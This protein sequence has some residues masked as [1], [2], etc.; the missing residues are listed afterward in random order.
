[1]LSNGG[2]RWRRDHERE[3]RELQAKLGELTVARDFV[4]RGSGRRAG[5]TGESGADHS[6]CCRSAA[7]TRQYFEAAYICSGGPLVLSD[8]SVYGTD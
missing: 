1:M 5:P 8:V 6:A 2:E 3:I 7:T 4:S